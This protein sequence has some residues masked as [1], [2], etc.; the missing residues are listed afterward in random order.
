[1][2]GTPKDD[3]VLREILQRLVATLSP[4]TIF[5]FGSRA[6]GNGTVESD[7]DLLVIISHSPDPPYRRAQRAE[8]ALWGIWKS[9][10]IIVLTE[11]EF[12]QAKTVACSLSATAIREGTKLYAT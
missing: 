11:K 8:R 5:L 3:P 9:A 6:R 4:K 1:M 10:D 7:Y 2:D 12:E